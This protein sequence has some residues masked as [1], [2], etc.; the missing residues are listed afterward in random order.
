MGFHRCIYLQL[1]G[2][3]LSKCSLKRLSQSQSD[4]KTK[5][6]KNLQVSPLRPHFPRV[7]MDKPSKQNQPTST[8]LFSSAKLVAEAAQATLSHETDKVDR[9][10]VAGAAADLLG[11][12]S[13]YGKLEEKG[14]GGYVDKAKD[15]LHQYGSSHST[16]ITTT[17]LE[18]CEA[19]TKQS[20]PPDASGDNKQSEG[21]GYGD[22]LKIAQGFMK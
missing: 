19:D 21:G 12:A 13:Q 15:Y 16:P 4:K 14:M 22:Y 2:A 5:G 10:K 11:A 7:S 18:D 9:G 1:F 8:D 6:K 17:G 20:P 3:P